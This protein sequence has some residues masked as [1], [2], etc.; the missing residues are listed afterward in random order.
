MRFGAALAQVG[1]DYLTLFVGA[2]AERRRNCGRARLG[3][4][5]NV[6][7]LSRTAY[8]YRIDTVCIAVTVTVVC[9]T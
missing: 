6:A 1:R 9:K 8:R 4:P 7:V 5:R 3:V 2:A